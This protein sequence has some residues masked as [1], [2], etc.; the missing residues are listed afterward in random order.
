VSVERGDLY[1]SARLAADQ[2]LKD[3]ESALLEAE[4]SPEERAQQNNE[5]VKLA[6]G[7][8]HTKNQ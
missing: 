3:K 5:P 4:L 2:N 7:T 1:F 6:V 8:G